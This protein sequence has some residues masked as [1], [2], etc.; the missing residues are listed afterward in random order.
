VFTPGDLACRPVFGLTELKGEAIARQKS[1]EGRVVGG[2]ELQRNTGLVRCHVRFT[3][4]HISGAQP[5]QSKLLIHNS[6]WNIQSDI[7]L[8]A[9]GI[10]LGQ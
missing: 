6:V 7:Y 2:N 10:Y 9:T 1:A 8:A 3:G 4:I 5:L